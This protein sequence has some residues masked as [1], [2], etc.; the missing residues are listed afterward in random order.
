M[1]TTIRGGSIVSEAALVADSLSLTFPAFD[2]LPMEE[3]VWA[4]AT[5]RIKAKLQAIEVREAHDR[6]R[7]NRPP[8]S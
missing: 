2:R 1:R 6:A 4:V 3:Q 7:A 5:R 8:R